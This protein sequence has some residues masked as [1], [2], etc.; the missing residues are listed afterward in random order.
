MGAN[1]FLT[2]LKLFPHV[3]HLLA[4]FLSFHGPTQ[5]R[6]FQSGL[7]PVIVGPGHLIQHSIISSSL[8]ASSIVAGMFYSGPTWQQF[9]PQNQKLFDFVLLCKQ[10]VDI[11]VPVPA[12]KKISNHLMAEIPGPDHFQLLISCGLPKAELLMPVKPQHPFGSVSSLHS[13]FRLIPS[14]NPQLRSVYPALLLQIALLLCCSWQT[15]RV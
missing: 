5:P 10:S 2:V 6:P 1:T 14:T 7:S 3:S 9:H 4:A 12:K 8:K 11:N 13:Y 15:C